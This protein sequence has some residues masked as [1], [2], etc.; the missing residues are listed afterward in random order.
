MIEQTKIG[1]IFVLTWLIF[2]GPV[3]YCVWVCGSRSV[4]VYP[5]VCAMCMRPRVCVCVCVC[6]H[7]YMCQ[8]LG[9]CHM[10]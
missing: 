7:M 4:Y 8:D 10:C 5:H 6:T 9:L 3:A 2:T 1:S